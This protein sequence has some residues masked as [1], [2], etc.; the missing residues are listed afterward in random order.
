[1]LTQEQN[2]RLTR[3]GPGTPMGELMRRYWHP[4]S[5]SADLS[6]DTPTKEVRLLGEDLVLFR[7]TSGKVGLIEPSCAHRKANLSYGIPEPDGIRCAYHG[8]LY[9]ETGQCIEQPSEPEGS[10][11]KEKVKLK[12][13]PV[14][15]LGG[16]VFAYM[17]PEP[18]PLLPRWDALVWENVTRSITSVQLPCNWLQ[19]QENSLDP[20]HF[21][22]LHHYYGPYTMSRKKGKDEGVAFDR[23]TISRGRAHV[24]VGFD[25]T[26]YGIIKRRLLEGET[27]EDEWWRIG[28]PIIFPYTL[29]VG[30][31]STHSFQF[32]VPIDDT[33][34]M[35]LL[36]QAVVPEPGETAPHQDVIPHEERPLYDENGR[37]ND[38]IIPAQDELA[39]VIQGPLMDRTTER[40]GVTDQGLIMYRRLLEEQ[41][42]V[43]ADGGDPLNTHR[44]PAQNQC[45]VLPQE[46]SRYPEEYGGEKG[47]FQSE[48]PHEPDVVGVL[49]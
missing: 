17:G 42:Q 21:Q 25:M 40:L 1:M 24:K 19:C 39:W 30:W 41:M 18:I 31:G 38:T 22:W 47:P 20:V 48:R 27:E 5:A 37:L 7:N 45:I 14:Q 35:H 23:S 34:T 11:F 33:H 16:L 10:R 6:E 26:S 8:W 2:E 12:A 29:R 46:Y 49:V 13:Y 43:V 32:R 3:V 28:H 4:I 36:Y 44:D 15:E 9:D